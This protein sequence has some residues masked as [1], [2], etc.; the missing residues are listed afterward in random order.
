MAKE[1]REGGPGR[2][3]ALA[4]GRPRGGAQTR[5]A[6]CGA[7][8]TKENSSRRSGYCDVCHARI[9]GEIRMNQP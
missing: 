8:L 7:P 6:R 3:H 9:E 1:G 5:C 2:A 4:K